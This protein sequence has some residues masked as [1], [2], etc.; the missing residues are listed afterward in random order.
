MFIKQYFVLV[1]VYAIYHIMSV[2]F[3]TLPFPFIS[4]VM[5]VSPINCESSGVRGK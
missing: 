1:A 3:S 2:H 5:S 4:R